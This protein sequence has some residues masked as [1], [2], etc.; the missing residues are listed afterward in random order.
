MCIYTDVW[1][2]VCYC[3][4]NVHVVD[5]VDHEVKKSGPPSHYTEVLLALDCNRVH[6]QVVRGHFVKEIIMLAL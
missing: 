2:S 5:S 3:N 6:V 1:K 4:I